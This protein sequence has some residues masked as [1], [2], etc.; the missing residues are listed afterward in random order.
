MLQRFVNASA[1]A[2]TTV[3]TLAT[4]SGLQ[5]QEPVDRAMIAKLRSESDA[6]SR[7]LESYRMLTDVIGPRLT[8]TPGF[9]RSV[10]WTR[11]RLS[12]WGMSNVKVE[13]WPFGR[14]WTLEKLTLE[15]T[16]PRYFPL[17]GYPEAWTPSTKGVL[18]ATPIYVGDKTADQ[19]K[20]MGPQLRDSC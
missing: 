5:A 2:I 4:S 15:M 6:R 20:A 10:D 14:G 7:V 11:D 18:S 1:L 9:K 17:E 16:E 3:C 19:I 12:E 8:G 13:S